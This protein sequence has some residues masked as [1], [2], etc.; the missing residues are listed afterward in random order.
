[1]VDGH[2][3][4]S[5]LLLLAAKSQDFRFETPRDFTADFF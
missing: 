3:I 5:H 1:M 2:F 4:Q